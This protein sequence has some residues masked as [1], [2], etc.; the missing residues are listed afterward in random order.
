M[1]LVQ[2]IRERRMMAWMVGKQNF[3]CLARA[4]RGMYN[5]IACGFPQE[6]YEI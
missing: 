2:D 5:K 6:G 1:E 4:E 3:L